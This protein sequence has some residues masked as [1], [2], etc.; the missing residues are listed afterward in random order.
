V[1]QNAKVAF[2]DRSNGFYENGEFTEPDI[3]DDADDNTESIGDEG[4]VLLQEDRE[5]DWS[6]ISLK[7]KLLDEPI[8]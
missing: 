4:I 7:K 8:Y 1:I 2:E 5:G 3:F 6:K